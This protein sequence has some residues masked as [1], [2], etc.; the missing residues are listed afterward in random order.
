M[1]L[2]LNWAIEKLLPAPRVLS[3]DPKTPCAVL[4]M[5]PATATTTTTSAGSQSLSTSRRRVE[6]T[7]S[8]I[9]C[10]SRQLNVVKDGYDIVGRRI[11]SA[12]HWSECIALL[13]RRRR[14]RPSAERAF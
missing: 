12:G 2:G 5:N 9:L 14:H 7:M 10:D 4:M 1:R 8:S 11:H 3:S 13:A 6:T